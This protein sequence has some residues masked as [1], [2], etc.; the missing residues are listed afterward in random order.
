MT[1]IM[2]DGMEFYAHHGCFAEEQQVG[3]QFVV[4]VS[5]AADIEQAAA[6]DDIRNTVNYIAVY[7]L[8]KAQM[9][10]TSRLIEHVAHRIATSI[11]EQFALVQRVEVK[12]AKLNPA[13][14]GQMRQSAATVCLQRN[15]E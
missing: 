12:I 5:F 2:L 13:V 14:G 4:N 10:I 3:T 6:T 9:A 7:Q 15:N 11:I 1:T 8:V